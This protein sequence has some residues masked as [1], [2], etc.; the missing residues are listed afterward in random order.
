MC[1]INIY[2]NAKLAKTGI[3]QGA[4]AGNFATYAIHMLNSPRHSQ[5]ILTFCLNLHF[6]KQD[7]RKSS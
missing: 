2:L 5:R 4:E 3:S 7:F 6:S 1:L